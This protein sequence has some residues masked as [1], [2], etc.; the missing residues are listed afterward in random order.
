MINATN[1]IMFDLNGLNG[2]IDFNN[3]FDN[4][5]PYN[6]DGLMPRLV[7]DLSL[8]IDTSIDIDIRNSFVIHTYR[9]K[10]T[11]LFMDHIFHFS[12]V[13][14]YDDRHAFKDAWATWTDENA[15]L[16]QTEVERLTQLGY[17]GNIIEKMFKSARYYFRKKVVAP[18][19]ETPA[20]TSRKQYVRASKDLIDCIDTHIK[21]HL[22]THSIK[23]QDGFIDFCEKYS[24]DFA[25]AARL[26]ENAG[27]NATEIHNKIKKTYKNRYS[28][29]VVIA[30]A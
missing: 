14:Q 21:T 20:L 12:K 24:E 11:D 13:H 26:F 17:T 27:M 9:F 28:K 1:T 6:N 4:I 8:A 16:V 10:F 5:N 22:V 29:I 2:F 15:V 18:L 3:E 19:A 23:P 7:Q 25:A 30:N